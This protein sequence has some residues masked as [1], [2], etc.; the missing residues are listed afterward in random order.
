MLSEWAANDPVSQKEIDRNNKV[1][2]IQGNRNPYIDHQEYAA[3]VF[4]SLS[5]IN[6]FENL[7]TKVWYSNN[8]L[9]IYS[10]I[11]TTTT[12]VIYNMLGEQVSSQLINDKNST[13]NIDLPN[14]IYLASLNNNQSNTLKFVV[15]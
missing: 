8:T 4:G 6:N 1:Y 11:N 10:T 7:L 3:K 13:I 12:L 2:Q 9:N 14:G 15:N 5:K